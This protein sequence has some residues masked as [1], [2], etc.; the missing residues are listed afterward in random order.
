MI[1]H[2]IPNLMLKKPMSENEQQASCFKNRHA[3]EQI[4]KATI[5]RL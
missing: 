5:T 4:L 2:L 3:Y 1:Y